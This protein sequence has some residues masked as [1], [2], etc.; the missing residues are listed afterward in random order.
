M[1]SIEELLENIQQ[2]LKLGVPILA[3][4]TLFF[5]IVRFAVAAATII[6]RMAPLMEPSPRP[7]REIAVVNQKAADDTA[8]KLEAS[9]PVALPERASKG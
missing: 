4:A 7:E 8:G 3:Q 1:L 6:A 2:V 5:L 9:P